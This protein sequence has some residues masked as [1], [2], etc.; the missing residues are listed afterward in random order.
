MTE[1]YRNW[2]RPADSDGLRR[3]REE[4]EQKEQEIAR[5]RRQRARAERSASMEELR[6]ELQ[7]EVA[8]LR[9]ELKLAYETAIEA[10]GTALGQ[11]ADKVA[12]DLEATINKIQ[13]ELFGLVERRFGELTG[14]LD[15]F[16]PERPRPKDFKF[17]GEREHDDSTVV[18][19]PSPLRRRVLDS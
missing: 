19:L 17:A 14:R 5:G 16:L 6:A 11:V 4:A 8:S 13:T 3:W 2:L 7:Q 18:D 15:G 1:D 10:T 12:T 9:A